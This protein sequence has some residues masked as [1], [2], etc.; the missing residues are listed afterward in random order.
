MV[1]LYH[2][3]ASTCSQKVRIALA[4]KGL[5]YESRDVDLIGGGQHDP[6]YVKLNPGHVVP[7]LVH[8]GGVYT[9]STLINE[10][11][12]DAFP[13]SPLR[14]A[15]AAGLHAMR[16]WTKRIDELHPS[17][18]ISAEEIEAMLAEIPDSTRRA[19]RRSVIEHGVRSPEVKGAIAAF[20]GVLDV[21]Q[22]DLASR[23]WLAGDA[24]SQADAAA[25]PYVLR[26]DHLAM[27]PL[28]EARP[29]VA[30]WYA[31]VQARKS[32]AVAIT[33]MLPAFIIDVFRSN[34]AAV[35]DDVRGLSSLA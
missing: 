11:L 16:L 20:E 31:R 10:Y 3:A 15:D 9:E 27:T 12:D 30:D 19:Q 32:F 21:M 29:R 4:E 35:W 1:A 33:S 26:L 18:G 7:T 23:T 28:V 8:D 5:D 25:L 14:P 2:N 24:F 6:E 22:A 13:E 34:G 17:A